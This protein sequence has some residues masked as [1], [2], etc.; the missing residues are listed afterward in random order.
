M[1]EQFTAPTKCPKCDGAMEEG[2]IFPHVSNSK[3]LFPFGTTDVLMWWKIMLKETKFMGL[4]TGKEKVITS[5]GLFVYS[6]RCSQCGYVETYAPAE[7]NTG[8]EKTDK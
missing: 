4:A 6:Y 1:A 7:D 8:R 2:V 3:D 5:Q